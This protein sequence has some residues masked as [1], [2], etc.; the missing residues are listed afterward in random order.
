M[1]SFLSNRKQ[2]MIW[3]MLLLAILVISVRSSS[4][5]ATYRSKVTDQKK[6]MKLMP[7]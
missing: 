3:T 4:E 7:W 2:L 5:L 6:P 1:G